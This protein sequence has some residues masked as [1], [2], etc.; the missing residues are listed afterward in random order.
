MKNRSQWEYV[1]VDASLFIRLSVNDRRRRSAVPEDT[2]NTRPTNK[3]VF[4]TRLPKSNSV[5]FFVTTATAGE[6]RL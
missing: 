2:D 5:W 4:I 3:D 1:Y 6:L